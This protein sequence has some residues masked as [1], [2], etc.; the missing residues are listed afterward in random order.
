MRIPYAK[1]GT[2]VAVKT[3]EWRAN[4]PV[5]DEAKC[6]KCGICQEYCPEGIMGM[7]KEVPDID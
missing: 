7:K 1:P 5:V 6:I 2:T 3:G 4:R